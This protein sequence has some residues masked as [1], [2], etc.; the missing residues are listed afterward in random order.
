MNDFMLTILPEKLVKHLSRYN[1]YTF[2]QM[3]LMCSLD[4]EVSDSTITNYTICHPCM[5]PY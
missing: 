2:I 3:P 5:I 4:V 1:A